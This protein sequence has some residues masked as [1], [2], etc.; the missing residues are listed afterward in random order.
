MSQQITGRALIQVDGERLL[1][2]NGANLDPGGTSREAMTGGGEVQG[3]QES[4]NAPSLSVPIRHT[5]DVS[6]ARLNSLTDATV[7]FETDNGARWI[8]R[9][10]FTT[11]TVALDVSAGNVTLEMSCMQIDEV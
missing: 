4:D 2:E 11:N 8:L 10:A 3:F 9:G 6:P 5:K 1:T 7:I